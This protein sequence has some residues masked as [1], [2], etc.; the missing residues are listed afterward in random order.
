MPYLANRKSIKLSN[1]WPS[2]Y[3]LQTSDCQATV[4]Q[5][6]HDRWPT[7][8][9]QFTESRSL[10]S[11]RGQTFQSASRFSLFDGEEATA[12]L[13]CLR[14]QASHWIKTPNCCEIHLNGL[15]GLILII[16]FHCSFRLQNNGSLRREMRIANSR[17]R[18]R[19]VDSADFSRGS[20]TSEKYVSPQSHSCD[21]PTQKIRT[22][23]ALT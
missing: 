7:V 22:V 2:F 11:L 10:N 17:G 6:F 16:V 12:G 5:H 1:H 4:G 13:I 23:V 8:C 19:T 14:S 9:R 15:F 21:G 3:W 18:A 20:L